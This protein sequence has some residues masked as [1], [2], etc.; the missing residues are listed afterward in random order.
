MFCFWWL[1]GALGWPLYH[2]VG[3]CIIVYYQNFRSTFCYKIL[4]YFCKF[5]HLFIRYSYIYWW[6]VLFFFTIIYPISPGCFFA[7]VI[8]MYKHCIE[9]LLIIFDYIQKQLLIRIY[10]HFFFQKFLNKKIWQ[11]YLII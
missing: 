7:F 5:F 6:N 9:P 2:C 1:T 11:I 10:S 3:L 4:S 8:Y